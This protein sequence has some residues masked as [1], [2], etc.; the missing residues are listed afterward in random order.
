MLQ[1]EAIPCNV[2]VFFLSLRYLVAI[3]LI[4]QHIRD[5]LNN[6]GITL[7]AEYIKDQTQEIQEKFCDSTPTK[8]FCTQ[9]WMESHS[10]NMHRPH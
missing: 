5:F 9:K 10:S 7:Q 8:P 6:R 4:V 2:L 1:Q 3:E